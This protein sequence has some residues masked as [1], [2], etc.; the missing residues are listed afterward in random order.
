MLIVL[1]LPAAGCESYNSRTGPSAST[2]LFSAMSTEQMKEMAKAYDPKEVEAP[3]YQ[4]WM[5][6]G[7]FKPRIDP[8]KTPFCIIMP[9]PNVTGELHLGHALTATMEDLLMRWHRMK[10]DSALWVPGVDH[11]EV[12]RPGTALEPPHVAL[13]EAD[14]PGLHQG[15]RV[16]A[17]SLGERRIVGGHRRLVQRLDAAGDPAERAGQRAD[18]GA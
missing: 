4:M 17:A 3:L 6:K 14:P 7:Y 10:G 15:A 13:R 18:S 12:Q 16:A 8:D 5:D 9:P 11:A 2:G 1:A